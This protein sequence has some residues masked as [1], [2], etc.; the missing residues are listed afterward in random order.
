MSSIQS[1]LTLNNGIQIPQ[2]GLGVYKIP[3]G[4]ETEQAVLWALEAGYRHIDTAIYYGNEAAVGR[5]IKKSGIPREEIFVTTKYLPKLIFNSEAAFTESLKQLDIDYID[6]FL[7]HWPPPVRKDHIWETFEK[8]YANGLCKAIGV[9][10]YS[11][12]LLEKILKS[13][14]IIPAVNQVEFS[15]F[16]YRKELLDFCESKNIKLEAYSPLT[17]GKRLD[18]ALIKNL[19][20]KYGKSPAQIMIR[21]SL[22][23]GLVVLPKSSNQERI[24]ENADVFDFTLEES[25][26]TALDSLNENYSALFSR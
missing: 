13:A 1:T 24:K 22:Q 5:A 6:L 12:E 11:I 2:L 20:Q 26:M 7:V 19:A 21:W 4:K 25:D 15:P 9:S 14:T 23:H 17:R 16:L 3:K 10:N 8:I 18:D